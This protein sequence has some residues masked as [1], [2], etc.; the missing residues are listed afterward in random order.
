[1]TNVTSFSCAD[2]DFS[3]YLGPPP[4]ARFCRALICLSSTDGSL[5][6]SPAYVAI[7]DSFVLAS[8]AIEQQRTASDGN[9]P[10]LGRISRGLQGTRVR[11]EASERLSKSMSGRRVQ[12]V[13]LCVSS[14][15]LGQWG[16][17]SNA[18]SFV[19]LPRFLF[20]ITGRWKSNERFRRATFLTH[21]MQFSL[22]RFL[23]AFLVSV[24]LVL[25]LKT[26]EAKVTHKVYFDIEHGDKSVGRVVMGLYGEVVPKTVENFVGLAEREEGRGFKGSIFHRVIKGFMIQGGDYTRGDGR[27]GMSI[28][29]KRFDDENFKLKHEGAGILSMANAGSDTNGSQFFITVAKTPWLDGRHVVFGR[30][31]EGMDVVN[32]VENVRT[33]PGDRPVDE[34]RIFDAGLLPDGPHDEL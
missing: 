30:V 26:S 9:K 13:Y 10:T 6:S 31:L 1:M 11:G 5:A 16:W 12:L 15:C 20:P 3:F 19:P 22:V 8:N 18:G 21:T 29:G 14:C 2:Q 27:G 33:G 25:A 28:W 4:S 23:V 32:Y 34:V 17:H 24:S 7:K